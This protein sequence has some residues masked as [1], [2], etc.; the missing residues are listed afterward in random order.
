VRLPHTDVP[1]LLRSITVLSKMLL[2]LVL[3]F[4]YLNH[5]CPFLLSFPKEILAHPCQQLPSARRT[6][7]P[8]LPSMLSYVPGRAYPPLPQEQSAAGLGITAAPR[9]T[10]EDDGKKPQDSSTER[11]D[12]TGMGRITFVGIKP[13]QPLYFLCRK[14]QPP[15]LL[16]S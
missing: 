5:A 12:E 11:G 7:S 4:K 10:S 13:S 6:G 15:A 1:D 16:V 9:K 3:S 14:D 2:A 8:F